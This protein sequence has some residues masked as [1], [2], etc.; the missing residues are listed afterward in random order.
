MNE[1]GRCDSAAELYRILEPLQTT[2]GETK[3]NLLCMLPLSP[4]IAALCVA[5]LPLVVCTADASLCHPLYIPDSLSL[6]FQHTSKCGTSAKNRNRVRYNMLHAFTSPPGASRHFP[7]SQARWAVQVHAAAVFPEAFPLLDHPDDFKLFFE[8][9]T[10]P[11]NPATI[12]AGRRRSPPPPSR[13]D[14]SPYSPAA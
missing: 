3:A 11:N 5:C 10:P 12:R 8:P 7:S 14:A 2:I 4:C 6:C 13:C 9:I 1:S